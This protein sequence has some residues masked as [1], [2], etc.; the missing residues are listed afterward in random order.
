MSYMFTGSAFNQDIGMWI[1]SNV[2]NMSGMFANNY[3]FN[4]NIRGWSVNNVLNFS[5]MF[6]N[7]SSENSLFNNGADALSSNTSP[8]TW[9]LNTEPSKSIDMAYMFNGSTSFSQDISSWNIQNVTNMQKMFGSNR[10]GIGSDRFGSMTS[11]LFNQMLNAWATL[12]TIPKNV[13]FDTIKYTADGT[14]A[15]N[16]LK[17]TPNNWFINFD[18][19]P[20]GGL[21]TYSPRSVNKGESF[22]LVYSV[23]NIPPTNGTTYN[24]VKSDN[25]SVPIT[26]PFTSAGELQYTFTNVI[27]NDD[28]FSTLF[29]VDTNANSIVDQIQINI[30]SDNLSL[31]YSVTNIANMEIGIYLSGSGNASVDWGDNSIVEVELELL[32]L[33]STPTEF[34]HTYYATGTY[35]VSISGTNISQLGNGATQATGINLLSSVSS[36]GNVGLTSLN[37]AFYKATGLNN[38]P[39]SLP[40]TTTVTDLGFCFS[41]SNINDPDIVNWDTSAVTNMVNMFSYATNFDQ[42]LSN[43]YVNNVTVF[44]EMFKNAPKFNNGDSPLYWSLS[45]IGPINMTSMFYG[46]PQFNQDISWNTD[47]VCNMRAMFQNASSFNQNVSNWNVSNVTDFKLMFANAYAF[48]NGN[49][50][51]NWFLANTGTVSFDYMFTSA[52]AFNQDISWNTNVVTSMEHMFQDA[53]SFNK[54]VSGWNVGNVTSFNSMFFGATDFNNGEAPLT[55]NTA[56]IT[57]SINA[58]GPAIVNMESIFYNATSFS[59]DISSWNV[60][61][62]STMLMM[63]D[64]Y[65]TS[66]TSTLFNNMLNEWSGRVTIPQNVVLDSIKYTLGSQTALND[67]INAPNNW[68]INGNS[69]SKGL[70]T[71]SPTSVNSGV[72]FTLVYTVDSIPSISGHVYNLINSNN[73]STIISSF[74]SAGE[75]NYTFPNVVLYDNN[76]STLYIIDTSLNSIVDAVYINTFFPCFKEGTKILT[77]R[78]YVP[79]EHLRK[80]DMVKTPMDEYKPVFMIGKKV[81]YNHAL[82]EREKNQLYVCSP[83][84]YPEVFED[85]VITGCHSILE[86]DFISVEQR[87]KVREINGGIY[88]TEINCDTHMFAKCRVPAC[89]DERT[90]IFKKEGPFTIYHIALEN[91]NMFNNYGIYANG[92]LVETCSKRY[93]TEL[94]NMDQIETTE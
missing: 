18:I 40:T 45:D 30:M 16:T 26:T 90:A 20:N 65:N 29:I 86:D 87:E 24:L 58:S 91:D 28:T 53:T 62:V 70:V 3:V 9:V 15:V 38:I 79:I 57:W 76:Y 56:P 66:M 73:P 34:K 6:F 23:T 27:L 93:L 81:I 85:L 10:F 64:P 74:T 82:R 59:Q 55:T 52:N 68:I 84:N 42:N 35:S 22:T 67:L 17:S 47:T 63:F 48:N 39:Y 54:N 4:Q 1:T 2:I 43:W 78:G 37:G 88:I 61:N 25:P 12:T 94:S 49:D 19:R 8:L 77:D 32:S 92:L 5:A 72:P 11:P 51:L 89:V 36:F 44:T 80:G 60:K 21:V 71:Y 7:G 69:E 83:Q 50:R 13:R 41:Y 75:A 46:A 14:N 31:N 33:S